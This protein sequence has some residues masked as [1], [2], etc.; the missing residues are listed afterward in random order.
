[1][2]MNILEKA[3]EIGLIPQS[4]INRVKDRKCPF[5]GKQIVIADFRDDL[6]LKEFTISGICQKCKDEFFK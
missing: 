1:M 6:S 2:N 4:M 5:C 3:V